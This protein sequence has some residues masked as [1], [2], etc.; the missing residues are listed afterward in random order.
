MPV[1]EVSII[2]AK[3]IAIAQIIISNGSFII[4]LCKIV[5][6]TLHQLTGTY[7]RRQVNC[8]I[9]ESTLK[10]GHHAALFGVHPLGCQVQ[11]IMISLATSQTNYAGVI[12]FIG[13]PNTKRHGPGKKIAGHGPDIARAIRQIIRGNNRSFG[14][15]GVISNRTQIKQLA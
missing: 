3:P 11:A 2:Q 5:S 9:D 6:G 1:M 7:G 15:R 13:S 12:Y 14:L 10:G 4:T 8:L